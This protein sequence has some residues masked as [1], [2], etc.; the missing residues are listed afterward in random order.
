MTDGI[1]VLSE[2]KQILY[3]NKNGTRLLNQLSQDEDD[4]TIVPQELWYICQYLIQSKNLFPD[5]HWHIQS[6]ILISHSTVLNIRAK[7]LDAGVNNSS[8]VLLMLEDRQQGIHNIAKEESERYG[9]T[10][11]EKE[12]WT[13]HRN[14]YT[15]KQIAKELAITPNTVKKHMRSIYSKKKRYENPDYID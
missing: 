9:L 1:L 15:Y 14:N 8:C 6:D 10:P 2:E 3:A 5:Q 13:L 7:W 12:V 4:S 11:R